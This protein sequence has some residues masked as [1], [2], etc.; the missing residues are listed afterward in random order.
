MADT[1]D[2]FYIGYAPQAPPRTAKHTLV[3]IA[4][5]VVLS[6][7]GATLVV[8]GM[9]DPGPGSWETGAPTSIE[10]PLVIDPYPAVMTAHGPVLVV[11]FGK[12]GAQERLKD[13]RAGA[14][15]M[16]TGYPLKRDDREMLELAPESDAI[17]VMQDTGVAPSIRWTG[18]HVAFRGEIVDSKCYLGAMKPGE[19]KTHK[20][21]AVRCI[22]G[23]IPAVLVHWRDDGTPSTLLLSARDGR[24]PG[25]WVLP[26]VGEPV[27]VRGELGRLGETLVLGVEPSGIAGASRR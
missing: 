9:R 2:E 8:A 18:E 16:L 13:V 11:N 10:G 7:A 24:A 21:C 15:V 23:G 26:F 1:H 19:G 6:M 12:R 3:V 27:E 25:E 17:R 14:R 20:A 5:N 22:S 4:I